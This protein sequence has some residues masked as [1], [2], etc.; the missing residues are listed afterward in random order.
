MKP[1]GPLMHE[2]RLIE[3]MI[4]LI[5]QEV[6]R[7][8]RNAQAD[9]VFINNAIDFIQVYADRTHHGKEEDILFKS[10]GKK[11][12]SGDHLRIMK[13]LVG[14]HMF[15][16][17]T[18]GEL[19]AAKEGFIAGDQ[20]ALDV[21]VDR[22]TTLAHFYPEHIRKED[23]DFFFPVMGYFTREEQ[24]QMLTQFWEF[25]RKMIHEKYQKIVMNFEKQ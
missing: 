6:N 16:R 8:K 5:E 11:N 24:D 13:E 15:G 23:K 21:I 19:I 10:L 7:I 3:R 2:H 14:E 20:K 4:V 18:V 25:D 17:V 9:I 1:I 12:I 22:L